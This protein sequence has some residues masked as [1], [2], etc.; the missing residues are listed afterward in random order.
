[1]TMVNIMNC[2]FKCTQKINTVAAATGSWAVCAFTTKVFGNKHKR[3]LY[4]DIHRLK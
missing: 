4:R 1:M 2:T 3:A